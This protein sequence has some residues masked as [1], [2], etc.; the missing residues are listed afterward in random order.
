[1]IPSVRSTHNLDRSLWRD[2]HCLHC[3]EPTRTVQDQKEDTDINNI[4]R[5]FGV[6]GR[7]PESV[8]LPTY[9]DFDAVSDYR[10]AIET[11]RQ[12]EESFL[13]MPAEFRDKLQNS[14][15]RF[16]VYCADPANLDELRKY[17]LA[18]PKPPEPPAAA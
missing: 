7:L 17:G 1:M 3:P 12:A 5:N 10:T 11:V 2:I 8:R 6:T 15:Q 13:E 16:L 4:V 14:P 18:V 9:G